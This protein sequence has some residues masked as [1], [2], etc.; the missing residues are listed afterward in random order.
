MSYAPPPPG[1]V[2]PPPP[3]TLPPGWTAHYDPNGVIYYHHGASNTTQWNLPG[4]VP[5]SA[6]L[7]HEPSAP[8]ASISTMPSQNSMP[9]IPPNAAPSFNA[10]MATPHDPSSF[11][12][13]VATPHDPS[14]HHM[15]SHLSSQAPP[16]MPSA[17]QSH[18]APH[19]S[20]IPPYTQQGVP[21]HQISQTNPTHAGVSHAGASQ[22]PYYGSSVYNAP[23]THGPGAA[24][25]MYA[26]P[27]N[28]PYGAPQ[29]ASQSYTSQSVYTSGLI[30][31]MGG[32]SVSGYGGGKGVVWISLEMKAA[33][34]KD[35]DIIGKSDPIC[36]V[37]APDEPQHLGVIGDHKVKKWKVIG[38]TEVIENSTSPSW[39]KRVKVGFYFEQHQPIKFEIIDVDNKKSGKGDKLGSCI[40]TLAEIVRNG[41]LR[42]KLTS[43]KR[44]GN[45]GELIVRAHDDNQGGKV[46]L[47]LAFGGRGLDKKDT[48]GKS[49]PYYILKQVMQTGPTKSTGT[50]TLYKSK[51]IRNTCNPTW[52]PHTLK[53]PCGGVPWQDIQ[54]QI[55]VY[56][57]DKFTPH[58]FIGE[59]SFRM[60][61]LISKPYFDL[62]N[63]KKAARNRRYKNSGQLVVHRAEAVQLPHFVSY[64]QGG[65]K[66][67][68]HV[69]IDFTASNRPADNPASLHFINDPQRPSQYAQAL[70]AIG[71]ILSAYIPD[72]LITALGFGAILPGQGNTACFD[73]ALSGQPDAR[74][75]GVD[76]LLDA[77]RAAVRSVTMAG[78]TNFTPLI[79]N[80]MNSASMYPVSQTNQHFSILLILTDGI[81][82]DLDT[83]IDAII[84]CSHS[85]PMAIV[86]VGIGSA[87]FSSM[88]RLDGDDHILRN[89]SGRQA[90]H[91]IVQF[92]KFDT[93]K[94]LEVL[95]ADVLNE[96]PDRVVEYMVDAGVMPN[97]P[98]F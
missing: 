13:A 27:S 21:M 18:P 40:A 32:L 7:T 12:A 77:Y 51:E 39:A 37:L 83:T 25:G 82:T 62:I 86:I 4:P 98:Q 57:W 49:D 85:T 33:G 75:Q 81:I 38:K 53:I 2:R 14:S 96:I 23:Q 19:T 65:L 3:S 41:I 47:K 61:E 10:A 69:A 84:E 91:D 15:S 45:W 43:E 8:T 56:D 63:S 71:T 20:H 22:A 73:F 35:K 93:N 92:V 72:G 48:F 97:P 58:D 79:R 9:F 6:P 24:S 29:A 34:L 64:L 42:L 74:V 28:T 36:Y 1:G 30:S 76:G 46:R 59:A 89:R 87:D 70:F 88:E 26:R 55:S 94:S 17:V 68:F 44:S 66:L 52:E 95:A 78:P 31:G 16:H 54:F 67:D 5:P 50:S 90:H 60:S 11:N 80:T